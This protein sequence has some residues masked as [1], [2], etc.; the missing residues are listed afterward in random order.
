VWTDS[1]VI[2]IDTKGPHNLRDDARRKLLSIKR[3][4]DVRQ[5]VIRFV[6]V[7]EFNGQFEKLSQ[8]GYTLW[9]LKD[10]G[11]TRAQHFDT[12]EELLTHLTAPRPVN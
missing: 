2:C 12:L 10:D 8:D 5:L 1:E 3:R 11:K 4:T 7:G 6:T 9:G